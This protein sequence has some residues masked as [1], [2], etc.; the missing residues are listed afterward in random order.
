MKSTAKALTLLCAAHFVIDGAGHY[1]PILINLRELD[2]VK[3]GKIAS[4][5]ILFANLLQP[6][7]GMLADRIS[8]KLIPLLALSI[9]PLLM[10]LIGLV[11][12]LYLIAALLLFGRMGIAM[13][14]PV[15]AKM[16]SK[17]GGENG[18]TYLAIFIFCGTVGFSLSAKVFYEVVTRL[19]QNW[20]ILLTIPALLVGLLYLW[21]GPGVHSSDTHSKNAHIMKD[22][23]GKKK[24]VLLL[25]M[26]MLI[27][28]FVLTG[29]AFV[30][31]VA[32]KNWGFAPSVWSS[33]P[34]V[35]FTAGALATL[36]GGIIFR[37]VNFKLLQSFSFV[38]S[39]LLIALFAYLGYRQSI[40]SLPVLA[41]ASL[42]SSVAL[43]SN[44]HT[45]QRLMPQSSGTVSSLMMGLPWAF[46][47]LGPAFI[48]QFTHL[49]YNLPFDGL[50]TGIFAAAAISL[51]GLIF[52]A[53]LPAQIHP[54]QADL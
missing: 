44:I 36:A 15:A 29:L 25:L 4:L 24:L 6:V 47:G 50:T 41:L 42:T 37:K 32:Y 53:L 20:S 18:V 34:I 48:T 30:I 52:V 40:L 7:F 12:D 45:G 31:P 17:L 16:S 28:A 13:F 14:H 5:A 3:A 23:K 10:S 19:G 21:H 33:S 35:M 8:G 2:P 46:A 51:L 22:F 39:A 49:E 9:G 11:N 1:F 27:R 26:M 43:P 54:P 38:T